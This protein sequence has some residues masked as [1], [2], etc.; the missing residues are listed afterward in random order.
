MIGVN[1]RQSGE[2]GFSLIELLVA[3]GVIVIGVT[4]VLVVF[5]GT[6]RTTTASRIRDLALNLA[7]EK[8]ELVR[9]TKYAD[10][11]SATLA[12]SLGTTATRGN[13]DFTI[14][15]NVQP[16]DDPADGTGGADLTPVDYKS[17]TVTVSWTNPKPAS[18]VMLDTLINN[19]AVEP[20][21]GTN[22]AQAP[23]W[24]N[25]GG[26][27]LTGRAEQIDPGLGCYIQWD[28]NWATDNQGVVGYLVYRKPPDTPDLLL[29]STVAP[30]V[31]WFLDVWYTAGL[32]YDYTVKAFDAAGNVSGTCNMVS[33]VGPV[34]AVKPS[35]PQ[36]LAAI[37]TGP[38]TARL[39]WSASTDNS[40]VAYYRIFR[41]PAGVPFVNEPYTTVVSS[42]FDDSAL[43]VGASYQYY[44]TAVDSA[45][46]ES[47][48]STSVS[49]SM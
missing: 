38:T 13:V 12:A 42:P 8:I 3:A 34:D 30:S 32:S 20:I 44:L 4:A 40:Y 33:V 49:V 26:D 36:N 25:G 14:A 47:D 5:S 31:G 21:T 29:I 43:E 23:A 28:P 41:T 10:I 15:Y 19:N 39:S 6:F 9:N 24:P 7:N 27:V 45:G 22:D 37:K 35:V 1:R 16:V 46:N 17:V 11:D 18:S 48:K 2:S